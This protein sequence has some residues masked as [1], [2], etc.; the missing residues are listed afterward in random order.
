MAPEKTHPASAGSPARS[1][2][3]ARS[4]AATMVQEVHSETRCQ[5]EMP[6]SEVNDRMWSRLSPSWA[7]VR[8]A[9]ATS[10]TASS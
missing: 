9:A 3:V 1:A 7:S 6:M 4:L 5:R 10:G 8:R 2:G